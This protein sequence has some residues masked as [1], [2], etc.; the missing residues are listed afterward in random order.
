MFSLLAMS[1]HRNVKFHAI[2]AYYGGEPD[3]SVTVDD[4]R[5]PPTDRADDRRNARPQEDHFLGAQGQREE[6]RVSS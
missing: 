6:Q 4:G 1:L 5:G 2:C 3:L